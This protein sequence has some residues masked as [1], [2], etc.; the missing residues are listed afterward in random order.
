MFYFRVQY[1]FKQLLRNKAAHHI[2]GMEEYRCD[3]SHW[4]YLYKPKT[5]LTL[6]RRE[7]NIKAIAN[8]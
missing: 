2:D 7:F 8:E 6:S 3:F 4:P 5:F 1:P